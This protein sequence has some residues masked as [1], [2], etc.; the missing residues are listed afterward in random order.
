MGVAIDWMKSAST[1]STLNIHKNRK[2]HRVPP[3]LFIAIYDSIVLFMERFHEN[4]KSIFFL[5]TMQ[6]NLHFHFL[7]G[8]FKH[9]LK[10]F[11]WLLLWIM[12]ISSDKNYA[13]QTMWFA[14]QKNIKFYKN[15]C[16]WQHWFVKS[17]WRRFFKR[18]SENI[19]NRKQ[20]VETGNKH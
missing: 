1:F 2:L 12:K 19:E 6:G 7:L 13:T 8:A 5:C 15:I 4:N 3:S 9:S 20:S 11:C 16:N 10:L 17:T 14:Q 18:A